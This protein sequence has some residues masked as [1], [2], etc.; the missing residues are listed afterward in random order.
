MEEKVAQNIARELQ[1]EQ[2]QKE[3][4]RLERMSN[5]SS[6][7]SGLKTLKN[8]PRDKGSFDA[9]NKIFGVSNLP[10]DNMGAVMTNQ[11]SK[12]FV[13]GKQQRDEKILQNRIE[14]RKKFARNN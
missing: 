8:K 2:E 10:S 7:Y 11:F 9:L 6:F 13:S 14:L 12:D 1:D 5:A 3:Q 4:D